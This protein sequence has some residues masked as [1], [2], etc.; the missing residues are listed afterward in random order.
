MR[1]LIGLI[2]WVVWPPAF[3]ASW[4]LAR[5]RADP[6]SKA[7]DEEEMAAVRAR[8]TLATII[9]GVAVVA[10]AY[11][12]LVA[13]GLAQTSALFIGLPA[14]LSIFVVLSVTP[15]SAVG[16][17]LKAT[18][19]GLLVS[20]MFLWEGALCVLMSAPLFYAV[21]VAIATAVDA[22]R[23][24]GDRPTSIA[25]CIVLLVAV[26]MSLEGVTPLTTLNRTDL[27][28]ESKVVRASSRDVERA[29]FELPRFERGRPRPFFLRAG[30][31]TPTTTRIE[32]TD[33]GTR[34]IVTMRGGEM[35][36][37]GMEAKTGELVL[38]LEEAQPGL[39][40][41]HALADT[42]HMT[43]FL[44]FEDS[45]VRWEPIDAGTTR[46]TWTLR[47]RRGLDPAWYFGP[48]E[49]YAVTLAA[50]Y[51]IDAVATP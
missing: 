2:V 50:R 38:N 33:S 46:V 13:H 36:L 10:I 21:A 34:W 22:L 29:L 3:M 41:W 51:L 5:E 31:P 43:H 19:V 6:R 27:V 26:P 48:V 28:T 18:T 47:Y 37:N 17:A 16:V 8:R 44:T 39:V 24:S 7:A 40:R 30:F 14:L 45:V 23:R 1:S 25:S 11:R 42:S 4:A 35:L 49:R 32:R 15:Q 20:M 12:L 9:G